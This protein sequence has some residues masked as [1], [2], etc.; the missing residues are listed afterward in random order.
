MTDIVDRL[1][2]MAGLGLINSGLMDDAAK[3]IERLRSD[4]AQ[5]VLMTEQ[6]RTANQEIERLRAA[7][8]LCMVG[9]NHLANELIGKLGGGFA[10]RY[11]PSMSEQDALHQLGPQY[12]CWT[13][14]SC[15]MRAREI[16]HDRHR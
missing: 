4:R 5:L 6:L 3:E 14:W 1:R 12:D 11:P 16:S 15:I 13:C 9:G 8:E 2:R 10:T 7:L